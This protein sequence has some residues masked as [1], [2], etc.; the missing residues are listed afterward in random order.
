MPLGWNNVSLSKSHSYPEKL[1]VPMKV[2][3]QGSLLLMM[4]IIAVFD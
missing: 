4:I 1:Y 3:G 2:W